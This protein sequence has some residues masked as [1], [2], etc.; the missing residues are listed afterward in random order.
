LSRSREFASANLLA[1]VTY[2]ALGGVIF[3]FV[4]FLQITLG[5]TALQAG[6]ATLPIT[7]LLLTLSTPSGA[8]AQRIGPRIPLTIGA[9]LAGA[10]LLDHDQQRRPEPIRYGHSAS[11]TGTPAVPQATL[12]GGR[13]PACHVPEF[14]AQFPPADGRG[15]VTVAN[16]THHAPAHKPR[17]TRVRPPA[18][19]ALITL[20]A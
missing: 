13:H 7:A 18:L 9:V 19:P 15:A 17:N 16:G 10:G 2:A 1:L 12:P 8:N 3:L 20:I 6:A 11:T 4:A 5:Y 14:P